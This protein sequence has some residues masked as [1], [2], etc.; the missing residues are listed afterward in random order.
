MPD[1]KN[2]LVCQLLFV[3]SSRILA[4]MALRSL[5]VLSL[6]SSVCASDRPLR[7]PAKPRSSSP[8]PSSSPSVGAE[9]AR[10]ARPTPWADRPFSALGSYTG[11]FTQ[12]TANYLNGVVDEAAEFGAE[13]RLPLKSERAGVKQA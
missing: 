10:A 12:L 13:V 7:A 1:I 6:L 5:A 2:D 4:I 11:P 9:R 3:T 8:T